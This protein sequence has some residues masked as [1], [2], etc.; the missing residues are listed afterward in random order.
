MRRHFGPSAF[1]AIASVPLRQRLV[2]SAMSSM[3][4]VCPH[5]FGGLRIRYDDEAGDYVCSAISIPFRDIARTPGGHFQMKGGKGGQGGNR[6]KGGKGGKDAKGGKSG[7]SSKGG[8]GSAASSSAPSSGEKGGK[9]GKGGKSGKGGKGDD[10]DE[11]SLGQVLQEVAH[12]F[13][14]SME[15]LLAEA[16]R[17]HVDGRNARDDDDNGDDNGN[18]DGDGDGNNDGDGGGNNDNA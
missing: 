6:G 7:K 9:G 17:L 12:V 3:Y 11:V 5:C 1:S 16:I 18:N 8:T 14:V 13:G 4:I 10:S 2:V 15:E